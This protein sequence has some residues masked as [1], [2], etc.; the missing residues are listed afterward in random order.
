LRDDTFIFIRASS[1]YVNTVFNF[2]VGLIFFFYI[3]PPQIRLSCR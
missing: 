1:V 2:V 3:F